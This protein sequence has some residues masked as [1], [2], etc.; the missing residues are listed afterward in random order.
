MPAKTGIWREVD[1]GLV[2]CCTFSQGAIKIAVTGVVGRLARRACFMTRRFSSVG[3]VGKRW[4]VAL[5]GGMVC[6][7]EVRTMRRDV[8]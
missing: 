3:R 8:V 7:I 4:N 1:I 5:G 2:G 6:G